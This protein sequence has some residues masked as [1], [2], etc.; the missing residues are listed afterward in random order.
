MHKKTMFPILMIDALRITD[1]TKLYQIH[2]YESFWR[3]ISVSLLNFNYWSSTPQKGLWIFSLSYMQ[4][5]GPGAEFRLGTWHLWQEFEID[6][7]P[8]FQ[9]GTL[10]EARCRINYLMATWCLGI[11]SAEG[12]ALLENSL[13]VYSW[14]HSDSNSPPPPPEGRLCIRLTKPGLS[15]FNSKRYCANME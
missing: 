12:W 5:A 14:M 1:L 3:N 6:A 11:E 13:A 10:H 9:I 2:Y 7:L 8:S 4:I 15:T